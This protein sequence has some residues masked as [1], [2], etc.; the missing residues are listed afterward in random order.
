MSKYFIQM[1]NRI[2]FCTFVIVKW[3]LTSGY[4]TRPIDRMHKQTKKVALKTNYKETLN[5]SKLYYE[6]FQNAQVRW[7]WWR[8][9]L[10]NFWTK[11]ILVLRL[12]QLTILRKAASSASFWSILASNFI[13]V[14]HLEIA[15]R[16]FKK[17]QI[18]DFCI[19]RR[20]SF[21]DWS[22]IKFAAIFCM[23]R[24]FSSIS[25]RISSQSFDSLVFRRISSN[26]IKSSS[27]ETSSL[28]IAK[29]MRHKRYK[30]LWGLVLR[31]LLFA[32][33]L[34][35]FSKDSRFRWR[36]CCNMIYLDVASMTS[37]PNRT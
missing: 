16:R 23:T 12:D 25:F 4:E 28:R 2:S 10:I 24:F 5:E 32:F 31:N 36:D 8:Y 22:F 20:F 17:N 3:L 9:A 21:S 14:L 33:L 34:H 19:D 26:F 18:T 37:F 1:S 7:W 30:N 27:K 11:M 13:D 15:Y 35:F 29:G 6:F